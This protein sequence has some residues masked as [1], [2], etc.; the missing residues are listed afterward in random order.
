MMQKL[1]TMM[2]E[3]A[4]SLLAMLEMPRLIPSVSWNF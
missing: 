1:I 4:T 2:K 3:L